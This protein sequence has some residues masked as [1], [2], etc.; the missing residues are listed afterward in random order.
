MTE[1]S[2]LDCLDDATEFEFPRNNAGEIKSIPS[3]QFVHHTGTVFVRFLQ[4]QHDNGIV[5]AI[6]NN[7]VVEADERLFNQARTIVADLRESF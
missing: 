6:I 1:S 5:F 7:R 3:A 4:D 2:F